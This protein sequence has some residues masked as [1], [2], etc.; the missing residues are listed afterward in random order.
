MKKHTPFIMA[1]LTALATAL[2][3]PAAP[4]NSPA[5]KFLIG[6]WYQPMSNF[7]KWKSRGVNTLVGFASE[8]T[9][10]RDTWMQAA[11]KAGLFYI[12]KPTDDPADLKSDLADPNLLAWEQPDEPDG[13]GGIP[14][15]KIVENYKAWKAAGDKPVLLNLD[16]WRTQY[17]K[18][19]EYIEYCQGADWIAFDYYIINRGEGPDNIKK[20]GERL[21]KLKEWTGGK[22]RLFVFIECSDQNLRVTDWAATPD[23]TGKPAGPRMRCPTADEM[24]KQIDVAVAHGA[25]GI[26]Y[27]PDVIGRGW[28]SFDGTPPACDAAMKE[29][30]RK[31]AAGDKGLTPSNV[32]APTPVS[33]N[34]KAPLDGTEITVDGV[35]YI[36]K[37]K[38]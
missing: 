1:I 5:P 35:T 24:K 30:N 34:P 2:A 22:K 8:N 13:G 19:E 7:A 4:A 3:T 6:V 9:V 38:E 21:D 11:R 29:V 37:H 23:A 12:V 26:I 33:T 15:A 14:P 18:P 31:L 27:F 16:G 36:L 20:I 25:S 28:E 32:N 17:G 10:A